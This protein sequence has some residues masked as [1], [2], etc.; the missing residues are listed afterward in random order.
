MKLVHPEK[1]AEP[2]FKATAAPMVN[3]AVTDNNRVVTFTLPKFKAIDTEAALQTTNGN[4]VKAVAVC[5]LSGELIFKAKNVNEIC[6]PSRPEFHGKVIST[7]VLSAIFEA[8][9]ESAEEG[10]GTAD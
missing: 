6:N 5:D 1:V 3:V 9:N 2:E 4:G 7:A 10:D 8:L